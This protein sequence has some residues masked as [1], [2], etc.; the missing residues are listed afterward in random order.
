MAK[1]LHNGKRN[2]YVKLRDPRQPPLS[3]LK[4]IDPEQTTETNTLETTTEV[5]EFDWIQAELEQLPM[6][7]QENTKEKPEGE[8]WITD[9]AEIDEALHSD[10]LPHYFQRHDTAPHADVEHVLQ[11][12]AHRA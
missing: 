1:W 8:R 3:I 6:G 7:G 2:L 5:V 10:W 11:T 4:V 9:P 12:Y